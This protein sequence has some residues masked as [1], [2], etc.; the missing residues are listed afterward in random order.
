M[1]VKVEILALESEAS[2]VLADGDILGRLNC[3]T[4]IE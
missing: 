4:I 3:S 2:T 1:A